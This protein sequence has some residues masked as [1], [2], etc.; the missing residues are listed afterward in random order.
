MLARTETIFTITEHWLAQFEQALSEGD[1]ALLET[2][3][4]T[5]SHWRDVLAL[6]WRIKTVNG[7]DAIRRELRT[8]NRRARPV[9]FK[10]PPHRAA[11]RHVI[12]A[13]TDSIEAIFTFETTEGRGSGVVRLSPEVNNGDTPKAWTLLTALDEIKGHTRSSSGGHTPRVRRVFARLSRA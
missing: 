11:P 13:G 4:H 2:L 9:G 5:D 12:R 8:H 10:I 1:N 6:T 3:F 7:T